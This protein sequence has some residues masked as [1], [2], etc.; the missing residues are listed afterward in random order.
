MGRVASRRYV[1]PFRTEPNI[2]F[3]K[4]YADDGTLYWQGLWSGGAAPSESYDIQPSKSTSCTCDNCYGGNHYHCDCDDTSPT[5]TNMNE[6]R[7]N[8]RA[9]VA[10]ETD[11]LASVA[12]SHDGFGGGGW[13][14]YNRGSRKG[15]ACQVDA[16]ARLQPT[17]TTSS[18]TTTTTTTP[19]VTDGCCPC[20][21]I[22]YYDASSNVDT[23]YFISSMT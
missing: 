14:A 11:N 4:M 8:F 21:W 17:T 18:T 16:N 6:D 7:S 9:F 10:T 19:C 20:G 22:R 1:G 13:Q 3:R 15:C 23:C 12:L 5:C 2:I